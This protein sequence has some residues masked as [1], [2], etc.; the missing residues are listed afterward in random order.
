[1]KFGQVI[2]FNKRNTFLQKHTEDETEILVPDLFL[3]VKKTLYV[4]K[5]SNLHHSFNIF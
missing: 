5:A 4:A 3:F 1:M 2:E